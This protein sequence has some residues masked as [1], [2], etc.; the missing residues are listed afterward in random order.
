MN[1]WDATDD[2]GDWYELILRCRSALSTN[3]L[4]LF[5]FVTSYIIHSLAQ[6]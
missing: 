1:E 3:C 2:V 5:I 6:T 4:F